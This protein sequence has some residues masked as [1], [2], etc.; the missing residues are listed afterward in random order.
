M[1]LPPEAMQQLAAG[2]K[3]PAQKP[4]GA[5]GPGAAP[6]ASPQP[7][8][9]QKE[10]ARVNVHIAMNMLEQALPVF[11]SESKE[12]KAILKHLSGL[13]K[14][15]GKDDASDLVP[16]E[17]MQ[18]FKSLPQM[19]GGTDVQRMLQQQMQQAGKPQQPQQQMPAPKAMQ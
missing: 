10:A 6:M 16:A 1:N 8:E 11:G 4:Q 14:D 15:F 7:K 3:Q 5:G 2:Q 18:L 12:G 9:G 17:V 19:G 13:S